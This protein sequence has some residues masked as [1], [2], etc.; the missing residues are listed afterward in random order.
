MLN[1]FTSDECGHEEINQVARCVVSKSQYQ[2][3]DCM[4]KTAVTQ[5]CPSILYCSL[6]KQCTFIIV[7]L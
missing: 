4:D 5:V 7:I 1:I 2:I 6:E 3:I